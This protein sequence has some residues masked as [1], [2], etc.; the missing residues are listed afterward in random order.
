MCDTCGCG[1]PNEA[2]TIR[3]PGQQGHSHLH[4]H[5]HDHEH[6]H[7][8]HHDHEHSRTIEIETDVLTKNNMLAERNRGYFEAKNIFVLNLVSSPGAGKTTLLEKTIVAIK[9][10]VECAVI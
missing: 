3:K 4:G 5:S 9:N 8:H 1:Q 2:I 7:D 10:K 6:T